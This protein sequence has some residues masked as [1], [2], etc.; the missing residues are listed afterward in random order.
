MYAHDLAQVIAGV[1][2]PMLRAAL[3]EIVEIMAA[4]AAAYMAA[5]Q[6]RT[7][8]IAQACRGPRRDG[9]TIADDCDDL[10]AEVKR[11][12]EPSGARR[13]YDCAGAVREVENEIRWG[14][15]KCHRKGKR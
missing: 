13:A 3:A 1:I 11:E 10:A 7:D 15:Y 5:L 2:E 8:Q 6:E 4:Y 9:A 14:K 12:I